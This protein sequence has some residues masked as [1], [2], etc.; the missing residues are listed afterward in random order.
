MKT[1]LFAVPFVLVVAFLGSFKQYN[2]LNY[3]PVVGK[4][5]TNSGLINLNPAPKPTPLAHFP[6]HSGRRIKIP[7]L[8]YHYIGNNPNPED[9]ARNNLSV[10]PAKFDSQM[11]YLAQNGFTPISLDT[12]LAGLKG[13]IILPPKAI[14]L[15]I[16][17]GYADL[18][19]NAFPILKKY[20]FKATV[21]IPTGLIGTAY[22]A[23][24]EQL[25]QMQSSGLFSFQ[26][27]SVNHANLP[28]LSNER[29][30]FE[31]TESKK[32]LEHKFGIPVNFIAYP[33]GLSN[34]NVWLEV[35]KAGFIGG[36]GAWPSNVV[37]EGVIYNMPRIKVGEG[38]DIS[39]ITQ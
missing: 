14:A 33:Y 12:M 8:L 11:G 34:S 32:T 26:A 17:D 31:L 9:K 7:I 30:K 4:I 16:D 37:S 5:A 23:G 2:Y 15:T 6:V 39:K 21:F 13:N 10:T 1:F 28:S 3:Q 36:L 18:Y 24:W 27:H 22:Y 20:D 38:T 25:A 35:K 29:L 19:V